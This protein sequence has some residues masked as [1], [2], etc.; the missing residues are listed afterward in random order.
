LPNSNLHETLVLQILWCLW[1]IVVENSYK[2]SRL[3]KVTVTRFSNGPSA[4]EKMGFRFFFWDWTVILLKLPIKESSWYRIMWNDIVKG[5]LWNFYKMKVAY[6][7]LLKLI[8][9][10]ISAYLAHKNYI[11]TLQGRCTR[12]ISWTLKGSELTMDLLRNKIIPLILRKCNI[13]VKLYNSELKHTGGYKGIYFTLEFNSFLCTLFLNVHL[14]ENLEYTC[15][16]AGHFLVTGELQ[17]AI[18]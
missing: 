12:Q 18:I 7:S 13:W 2:L 15:A 9:N 8:I 14:R 1:T 17:K 10:W 5:F 16:Y 3:F 11:L 6:F 4:W